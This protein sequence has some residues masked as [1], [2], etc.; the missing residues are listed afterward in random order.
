[1]RLRGF[2]SWLPADAPGEAS[3]AGTGGRGDVEYVHR[4]LRSNSARQFETFGKTE[5]HFSELVVVCLCL[6]PRGAG[7]HPVP[8]EA[9]EPR[10][11]V[12]AELAPVANRQVVHPEH[13]ERTRNL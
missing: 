11:V 12:L 8:D 4:N 13:L 5:I 6:V 3:G 9:V 10:F 7:D 2:A 1:M